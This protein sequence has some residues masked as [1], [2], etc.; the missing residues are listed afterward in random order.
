[1]IC[2][3][4]R[5][6]KE[7]RFSL[8]VASPSWRLLDD[9]GSFDELDFLVNLF[10]TFAKALLQAAQQFLFLAFRKFRVLVRKLGVFLL[11][12]SFD[13]VPVAFD[14]QSSQLIDLVARDLRGCSIRAFSGKQQVARG[15]S[16]GS[17]ISIRLLLFP[18]LTFCACRF[19]LAL[20]DEFFKFA[21]LLAEISF[22]FVAV[23]L[24]WQDLVCRNERLV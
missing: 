6:L 1:L 20:Q 4:S 3:E 13:F 17:L 24:R 23:F 8:A 16:N 2:G 19:P 14:L 11:K 22:R 15:E 10:G 18:C 5:R 9:F 7:P 12:P 21:N